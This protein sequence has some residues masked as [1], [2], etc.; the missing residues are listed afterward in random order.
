MEPEKVQELISELISERT[1]EELE[2]ID[3]D[4]LI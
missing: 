4:I 2:M 3:F 1:V